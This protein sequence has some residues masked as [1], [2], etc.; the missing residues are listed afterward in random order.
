MDCI[1]LCRKMF[2]LTRSA[3]A[4]GGRK[5]SQFNRS[6]VTNSSKQHELR[7]E[8]PINEE[9]AEEEV[10]DEFTKEFLG[11]QIK[12]SD[13]QRLLLTAGSSIAALLDP[14]RQDMIACLGETTGEEALHKIFQAMQ[15]S[16]EGQQILKQ[17]PRI[18]TK[19]VNLDELK[20]MPTDT[21]G[22][23]YYKFLDD[24]VSSRFVFLTFVLLDKFL[25]DQ[26]VTPDSRLE[27]RF[28]KDPQLA[29]VMT[30]Y[31]ETHD[32]VHTILGMPT[33]MLGEFVN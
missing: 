11:N 8:E 9:T 14:R 5:S 7:Q 21:F 25:L 2:R 6:I 31:R 33:N 17:K 3:L 30:R 32:L 15:T 20:K 28:M 29:Y 10:L 16:E 19:T 26:Q 1:F 22:H 24:N 18:N 12:V 4:L 27:V 13:F 23:H